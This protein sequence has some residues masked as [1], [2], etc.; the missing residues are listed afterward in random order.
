MTR[1]RMIPEDRLP[2]AVKRVNEMR[3]WVNE[4]APKIIVALDG[5][6]VLATCDN[7]DKKHS[8]PIS[9]IIKRGPS[10]MR[11]WL[12]V[13]RYSVW[14]MVDVHYPTSGCSVSYDDCNVYA[15]N[16]DTHNGQAVTPVVYFQPRPLLDV[17][18]VRETAAMIAE[19]YAEIDRIQSEIND[20]EEITRPFWV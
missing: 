6:R 18:T 4:N 9:E 5:A 17:E 14:L 10:Y 12:D 7:I 2:E 20:L 19:K 11:A 3:A 13:S 1:N 8:A 16:V 15:G